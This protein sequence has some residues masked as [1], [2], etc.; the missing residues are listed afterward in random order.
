MQ[1]FRRLRYYL[2][3]PSLRKCYFIAVLCSLALCYISFHM[4]GARCFRESQGSWQIKTLQR[5]ILAQDEVKMSST[6]FYNSQLNAKILQ[7]LVKIE[8]PWDN[9]KENF[10]KIAGIRGKSD[11]LKYYEKALHYHGYQILYQDSIYDSFNGSFTR[12]GRKDNLEFARKRSPPSWTLLL[13]LLSSETPCPRNDELHFLKEQQKVNVFPALQHILLKRSSF[14]S[15]MS[16]AK[17]IQDLRNDI[18]SPLCFILPQQFSQLVHVTQALGYSVKWTVNSHF[19]NRSRTLLPHV[20]D[21][22]EGQEELQRLSNQNVVVQQLQENQLLILNHCFSVRVYILITSMT[23]LRAYVH[24]EGIV[25]HRQGLKRGFKKITGKLWLLSDLWSYLAKYNGGQNSVNMAISNLSHVLLKMLLIL[26]AAMLSPFTINDYKICQHCFQLLAVDCVFNNSLYPVVLSVSSQLAPKNGGSKLNEMMRT[27][28]GDT[29]NILFPPFQSVAEDVAHALQGIAADIG[30][31]EW[32]CSLS[33][34]ICLSQQDLYYILQ[35]RKESIVE[36]GF[37]QLYPSKDASRY[38]RLM[39]QLQKQFTSVQSTKIWFNYRRHTT[40]DLHRL[41]MNLERWYEETPLDEYNSDI[42]IN[43][44]VSHR[45]NLNIYHIFSKQISKPKYSQVLQ[46]KFE[47]L[48]EDLCTNDPATAPYLSSIHTDPVVRLYP[49]FDPA[50]TEYSVNVRFEVMLLRAWA[51]V[52]NCQSEARLDERFGTSRPTNITLGVGQNRISFIVV[53]ISL[54]E[55]RIIN[56]YNLKINRF[57]VTHGQKQFNPQNY[58]QICSLK[59]ECDMKLFHK[60]ECGVQKDAVHSMT[61][62]NYLT[63]TLQKP[64]CKAGNSQ[65]RWVLPCTNCTNSRTCYWKEA[66]WHPYNCRYQ[67]MKTEELRKCFNNRKL[68]FI[69]DSTNRGMM[70][71]LI[72]RLNGSLNEWDKTHDIRLY[73]NV[74]NGKTKISFVYYPQFWIPTNERPLFDKALYQLIQR[75]RPLENNSNTILIVGG[76]HWLATQH[77]YMLLRAVRVEHLHGIKLVMKTLGAGFHQPV[78]SVHSLSM[79][80][81]YKLILHNQG[82]SEFAQHHNFEVIDTFNMT[83]ARFKDFMQGKCSCHFH[84]VVEVASENKN[85]LHKS[86]KKYHVEGPI[87]A[88]YS[89][90]L[91]SQLCSHTVQSS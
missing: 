82:L 54:T 64:L 36:S 49:A 80:D 59:Q 70:H 29:L 35:S 69:G 46:S 3:M 1:L 41:M 83:S 30:L 60:E 42:D 31:L 39:E 90:I 22:F 75:S 16:M 65:G 81:Q 5:S 86:W 68:L 34:D 13:C 43:K 4:I 58:H 91:L 37:R 11:D 61:W 24:S 78:E 20:I 19:H 23:P 84:R 62:P 48:E 76:V 77:L 47:V 38:Q 72:E 26:E 33:N 87:N 74:N 55:P 7:T 6:Q 8:N 21:L 14:C 32:S 85:R 73:D 63:K 88:I 52:Y 18:I 89:E 25:I 51:T 56:S 27:L 45:K 71:Y 53:D 50:V 28:I 44:A 12:F 67:N 9:M 15:A 57:P 66:A 10:K 40:S 2:R 79:V 17:Y